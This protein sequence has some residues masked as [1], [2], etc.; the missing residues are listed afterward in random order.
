MSKHIV[1]EELFEVS[2]QLDQLVLRLQAIQS[3]DPTIID[4]TGDMLHASSKLKS[5]ST[6]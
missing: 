4:A 2:R 3:D 5:V 1:Q 6:W